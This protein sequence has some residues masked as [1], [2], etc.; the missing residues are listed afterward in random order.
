MAGQEF[1]RAKGSIR[2]M[3][4]RALCCYPDPAIPQP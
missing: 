1:G 2:T 3:F 4:A